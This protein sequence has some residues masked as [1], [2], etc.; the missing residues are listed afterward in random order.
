MMTKRKRPRGRPK[1]CSDQPI[2]AAHL[3]LNMSDADVRYRNQIS[4][5][6]SHS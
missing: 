5:L 1:L 2:R 3:E 6:D 4:Q